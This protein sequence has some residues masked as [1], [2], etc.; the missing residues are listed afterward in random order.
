[1]GIKGDRK[2][3]IN[4]NG[5]KKGNSFVNYSQKFGWI[6]GKGEKIGIIV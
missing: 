3:G 5:M 4:G 1:M 6:G 2:E